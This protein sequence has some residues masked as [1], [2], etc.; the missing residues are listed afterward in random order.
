[1]S[2]PVDTIEILQAMDGNIVVEF[3]I[4]VYIFTIHD[5]IIPKPR[6]KE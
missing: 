1:M 4:V 6:P 2:T 5:K 3:A